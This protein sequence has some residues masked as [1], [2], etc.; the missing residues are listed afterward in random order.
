MATAVDDDYVGL[1]THRHFAFAQGRIFSSSERVTREVM[2]RLWHDRTGWASSVPATA[3][4]DSV[5]QKSKDGAIACLDDGEQAPPGKAATSAARD[6]HGAPAVAT[7]NGAEAPPRALFHPI[8]VDDMHAEMD[9]LRLELWAARIECSELRGQLEA[10]SERAL[11]EERLAGARS[12]R[13]EAQRQ[14]EETRGEAAAARRE[15]ERARRYHEEEV[16]VLLGAHRDKEALWQ[17]KEV[18]VEHE[19][20]HLR[21]RLADA[22]N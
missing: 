18:E 4:Q 15:A 2:D 11:E 13:E 22:R 9:R 12:A 1:R 6:G 17:R 3:M 20:R 21:H 16:A 10:R 14:V 7:N 19:L 8:K 5:A